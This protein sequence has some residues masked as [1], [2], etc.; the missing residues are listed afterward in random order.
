MIFLLLLVLAFL[1]LK[2]QDELSDPLV[3]ESVATSCPGCS[4][5]IEFDWMVCPHCLLRLRESCSSCQ[6]GKL[7]SHR[8][9]PACGAQAAAR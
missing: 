7:I 8:Y 4:K 9:C 2:I 1:L 3:E 5:E 6:Q